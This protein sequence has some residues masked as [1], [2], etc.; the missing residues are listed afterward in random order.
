MLAGDVT[1]SVT[2]GLLYITGDDA[3]NDVQ[4]RQ[5]KQTFEGEWPG[6]KLEITGKNLQNHVSTTINGENQ[7]LVVAGVKSGV[8]IRLGDGGNGL[9]IGNTPRDSSV[10]PATQVALPGRISIGSGSGA[11]DIRLYLKNGKQIFVNSG[12]G[13][14]YVQLSAS[15]VKNL[16]L[17]SD[18]VRAEGVTPAGADD[19]V[20][21]TNLKSSGEVKVTSGI[22]DDD[23]DIKGHCRIDGSL[24]V[25][26]GAGADL[27]KFVG[28]TTTS[29]LMLNGRTTVL[30]GSG[31]DGIIMNTVSI[32]GTFG[33]D[34]GDGGDTLLTIRLTS[35]SIF[36]VE[37]G[38]GNDF[39]QFRTADLAGV[40]LDGGSGVDKLERTS[41][42]DLGDEVIENF[43]VDQTI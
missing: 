23:I 9:R 39:V 10:P 37:F 41:D 29:F 36:T 11:D 38:Q 32:S 16:T 18:P 28:A 22:G 2:D 42:S 5:L 25:D 4:I 30:G 34:L 7:T 17:N 27:L 20:L 19:W 24:L 15:T 13:A 35:S 6:A 43:E 1:V 14:D 3:S 21:I 31:A 26:L 33:A 8:V 12:D 40:D